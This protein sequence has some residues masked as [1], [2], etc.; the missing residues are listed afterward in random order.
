MIS[1]RTAGDGFENVL[2]FF[3]C[4]N[5]AQL[6]NDA[7]S[8]N[9]VHGLSFRVLYRVVFFSFCLIF[10]C[11]YP[12]RGGSGYDRRQ[13]KSN[14]S[15]NEFEGKSLNDDVFIK[16]DEYVCNLTENSKQVDG[17]KAWKKADLSK[18]VRKGKSRKCDDID[19]R[20]SEQKE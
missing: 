18:M 9:M 19:I 5:S 4:R 3:V 10:A 15:E 11:F 14:K 8:C 16:Q 20:N 12:H 7:C 17:G 2:N 1:S 13:D 6:L